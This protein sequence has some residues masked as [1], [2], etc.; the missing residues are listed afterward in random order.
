[1]RSLRFVG[2][3]ITLVGVLLGLQWFNWKVVFVIV[4]IVWGNN[5]EIKSY[6]NGK[7]EN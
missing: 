2:G 7:K 5:I 6:N 4:L 1:M 3:L